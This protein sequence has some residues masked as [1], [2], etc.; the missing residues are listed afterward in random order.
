MAMGSGK[1]GPDP[2]GVREQFTVRVPSDQMAVYRSEARQRGMPMGDYLVLAL[3]KAHE[4]PEPAYLFR[5]R[6]AP[7]LPLAV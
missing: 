7:T 4:L 2:K 3:A 1:P 6:G 5:D